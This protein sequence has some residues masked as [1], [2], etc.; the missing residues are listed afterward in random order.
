MIMEPLLG[1]RL[2]NEK[3]IPPK[4]K[5]IFSEA[6][7]NLTPA[8][9]ALRW[10]FN[11]PEI[12]LVLSG[13]SARR[14]LD[15]N[16]AAAVSVAAPN[17]LAK[18][19]TDIIDKVIIAFN[20]SNRI[21]CTGCG[22]CIPCPFGVNI[23]DCFS[24]YNASFNMGKLSA[25]KKYMQSTGAMTTSKGMASACKNC[26]KCEEHC[27]QSIPIIESLKL[28]KKRMEPFW[29]RAG[30]GLMRRITRVKSRKS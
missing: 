20:E 4:V 8:A 22:Y 14:D 3:L 10:L 27:P 9:R 6:G 15:D 11:H 2:A 23:T 19:E 17:T 16:L 24:S 5:A 29:F 1:G 26:G 12:T 21:K 18:E 13:M 7:G 25:L 30:T 28:V